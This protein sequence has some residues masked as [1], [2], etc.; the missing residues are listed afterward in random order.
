MFK[1]I[2]R[3]IPS[4]LYKDSFNNKVIHNTAKTWPR[5]YQFNYTFAGFGNLT[6][7]NYCW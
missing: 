2:C 6:K 7:A 4:E 5:G 3:E 1:N